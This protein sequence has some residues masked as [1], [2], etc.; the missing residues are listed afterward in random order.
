MNRTKCSETDVPKP[1]NGWSPPPSFPFPPASIIGEFSPVIR[2]MSHSF[3]CSH[4]F[5][6]PFFSLPRSRCQNS[7]PYVPPLFLPPFLL[8]R[9]GQGTFK[10]VMQPTTFF[11]F[12]FPPPLSLLEERSKPSLKI[13]GFTKQIPPPPSPLFSLVIHLGYGD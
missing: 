7:V 4:S 10:G 11:S 6:S 2:S 12:L 3:E 1:E 9:R 5:S 8:H 13:M